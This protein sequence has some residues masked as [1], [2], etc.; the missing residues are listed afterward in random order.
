MTLYESAA[1]GKCG[2]KINSC[3]FVR[4]RYDIM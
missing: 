2:K 3:P 4:F 1:N